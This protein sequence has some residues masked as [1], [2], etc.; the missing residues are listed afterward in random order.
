MPSSADI[1]H[2]MPSPSVCQNGDVPTVPQDAEGVPGVCQDASSMIQPTALDSLDGCKLQV[3]NLA[4][5]EMQLEAELHN[6]GVFVE[7]V[8]LNSL[9]TQYTPTPLLAS[10]AVPC[11][12]SEIQGSA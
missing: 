3:A 5:E 10:R 7:P 6:F 1:S 8:I 12:S 11:G 4:R 9:E 2:T